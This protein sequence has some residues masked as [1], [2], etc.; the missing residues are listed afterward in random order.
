MCWPRAGF[1]RTNRWKRSRGSLQVS[2][3]LSEDRLPGGEVD[4]FKN[5]HQPGQVH[6]ID[7]AEERDPA[8][9]RFQAVVLGHDWPWVSQ[10]WGREPPL[11][12]AGSGTREPDGDVNSSRPRGH[13][14]PRGVRPR[15]D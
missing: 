11:T 10:H 14:G 1:S 15:A 7:L 3:S 2:T 6:A 4:Q 8:D 5:P 13:P 12:G 9:E